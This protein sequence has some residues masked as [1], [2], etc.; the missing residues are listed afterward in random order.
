MHIEQWER[1]DGKSIF[2]VINDY[3]EANGIQCVDNMCCSNNANLWRGYE[4]DQSILGAAAKLENPRVFT[5]GCLYIPPDPALTKKYRFRDQLEELMEI[6]LDGVKI[7]DFKPDA[8]VKLNVARRLDE[9]ED[10]ISQCEKYNVHMCWHVADPASFWD[11]S[12]A[13]TEKNAG[14]YS[15]SIFPRYE[16]LI[17]YAYKMI[18]MHP[19]LNVQLAHAFFKS[20]EPDEVTALLE[21]YPNVTIDLAP[22]GE[23]F[24]GFRTYYDKW[25]AIFRKYS[26][27]FL[28]A[29]DKSSIASVERLKVIPEKV[30][31][32]LQ[33]DETAE[34]GK[35][36]IHGIKLESEY[37][38][39]ILYKNHERTVGFTPRQINRTALKKYIE[40][41]LP[42]MPDSRSKQ[43]AEEY[44][45]KNLL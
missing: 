21:K 16:E 36:I 29:T 39:N 26:E 17:A 7:C 18:D 5:H 19:R 35:H 20:F 8:Y 3:C 24:D 12:K 32:F 2:D 40:R 25:Y 37:L 10:Y 22:G 44:Y 13:D 27:R 23:M 30:M 41:Y 42:L 31:T 14:I 45:R 1:G 4:I 43:M 11:A 15:D 6:G 34:L 28:Y 9:Y 38:D 33:T